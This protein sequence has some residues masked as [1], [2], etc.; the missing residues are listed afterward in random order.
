MPRTSVCIATYRRPTGLAN[1]LHSLT[2]QKGAPPFD[3][4]VVDNDRA[5]SAAAVVEEF[6]GQLTLRYIVEPQRGLSRVRN[7]CIAESR[8]EFIAFIDDDEVA[9]PTWLATLDRVRASTKAAAV[10]GPVQI[11]FDPAISDEIRRCRLLRTLAVEEGA[12]LEWHHSRTG[13]AYIDRA[14]L[15]ADG[16]PFRMV[17][18]RTGGE[19]ADLFFRMGRAGATFACAG[20]DAAVTEFRERSRSDLGWVLR[21]SLRNGGNRAELDERERSIKARAIRAMQ[22]TRRMATALVKAKCVRHADRLA[23]IELLI[24]A[25]EDAGRALSFFGYRYKEYVR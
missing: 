9:A 14:T 23:Y 21:R 16:P 25:C 2:L 18:D 1:L 4:I 5:A 17:F 7:R 20:P 3:V 10:F 19:D 8:G 15:P 22:A 24:D 6:A 12:P 11:E 13:N